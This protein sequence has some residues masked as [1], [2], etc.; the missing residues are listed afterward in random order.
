MDVQLPSIGTFRTEFDRG[1]GSCSSV[2]ILA[3]FGILLRTMVKFSLSF[4]ESSTTSGIASNRVS[5]ALVSD[6]SGVK[7]CTQTDLACFSISPSSSWHD[8]YQMF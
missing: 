5:V 7:S 8:L 4:V 3:G 1:Q 2:C 6:S